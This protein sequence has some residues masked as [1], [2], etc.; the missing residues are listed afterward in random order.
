MRHA[1]IRVA[2]DHVHEILPLFR[3]EGLCID[4]LTSCAWEEVCFV[5]VSGEALPEAFENGT[6]F[7]TVTISI[8]SY[9]AQRL[10]RISRIEPVEGSNRLEVMKTLLKVIELEDLAGMV[11]HAEAKE[12]AAMT[13][14]GT[15]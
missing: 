2:L 9:G 8:E 4:H 6:R 12:E 14:Q 15:K 5:G 3:D 13:L 10:T 7:A 1:T 11:A